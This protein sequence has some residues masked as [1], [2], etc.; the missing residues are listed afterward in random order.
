LAALELVHPQVY[1][2]C[3]AKIGH[4]ARQF[5]GAANLIDTLGFEVVF[6]RKRLNFGNI[7]GICTM[8]CGEFRAA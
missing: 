7:F 4:S 6:P 5:H 3:P 2:K 1:L 8:H